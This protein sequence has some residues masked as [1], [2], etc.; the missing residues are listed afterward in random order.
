ML[1]LHHSYDFVMAATQDNAAFGSWHS[2]L[3]LQIRRQ[4][5]D[6]FRNTRARN[7]YQLDKLSLDPAR[8]ASAQ[9]ALAELG[10]H[11]LTA[12]GQPKALRR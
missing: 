11:Q 7:F 5:L 4:A 9:V 6:A 12:A 10:A 1:P 2:L 8:L 3:S